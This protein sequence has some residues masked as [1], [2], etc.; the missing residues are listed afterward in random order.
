[1]KIKEIIGNLV[2]RLV[3]GIVVGV[4]SFVTGV[5]SLFMVHLFL[6]SNA[7]LSLETLALFGLFLGIIGFVVSSFSNNMEPSFDALRII[8]VGVMC[9][10]VLFT[11]LRGFSGALESLNCEY[12]DCY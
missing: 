11:I 3:K 8:Y 7:T 12:P 5:L 1:M 10:C 2:G 9:L 4:S 6:T